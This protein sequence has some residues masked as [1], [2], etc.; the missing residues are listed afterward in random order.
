M[1]DQSEDQS[2]SSQ[3]ADA[4]EV[5]EMSAPPDL[6]DLEFGSVEV[7]DELEELPDR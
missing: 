2:S 5:S 6:T 7:G 4:S 3:T 1:P